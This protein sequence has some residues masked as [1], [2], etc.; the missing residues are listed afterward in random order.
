MD[1]LDRSQKEEQ[2]DGCGGAC[3]RWGQCSGATQ[4]QSHHRCLWTPCKKF[5]TRRWPALANAEVA[6]R[7]LDQLWKRNVEDPWDEWDAQW[8]LYDEGAVNMI[9][10][11]AKL[12]GRLRPKEAKAQAEKEKRPKY[13]PGP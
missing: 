12:Q 8:E 7:Y 9:S 10:Y 6:K 1:I 5:W 2:A 4:T 13:A 11:R 3:R